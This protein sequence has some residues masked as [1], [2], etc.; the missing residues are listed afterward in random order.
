M[1]YLRRYMGDEFAELTKFSGQLFSWL[2]YLAG[3]VPGEFRRGWKRGLM[4]T[5]I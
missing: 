4:K 5:F 3:K 1:Q 2:F